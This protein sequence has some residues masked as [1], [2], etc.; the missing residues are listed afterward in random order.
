MMDENIH[1]HPLCPPTERV[2]D[3]ADTV[4]STLMIHINVS[5][6]QNS[7]SNGLCP[8]S[9]HTSSTL[10]RHDA[11]LLSPH[12]RL[13]LGLFSLGQRK[14]SSC[15]VRTHPRPWISSFIFFRYIIRRVDHS[16]IGNMSPLAIHV[17]DVGG[18]VRS[19]GIPAVKR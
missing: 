19:G 5:S 3:L 18:V 13:V 6:M 12:R 4:N 16:R 10:A 9:C 1:S 11:G 15:D 2:L 7:V 14:Q 17:F 8:L